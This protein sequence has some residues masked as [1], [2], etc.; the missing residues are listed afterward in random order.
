MSKD[1][2]ILRGRL[3]TKSANKWAMPLLLATLFGPVLIALSMV[4]SETAAVATVFAWIAVITVGWI[5]LL[6][7]TTNVSVGDDGV[8]IER[9]GQRRFVPYSDIAEVA[10]L[11]DVVLRLILHSGES[12]DVYTGKNELLGQKEHYLERVDLIVTRIRSQVSQ[13][14]RRRRSDGRTT[15]AGLLRDRAFVLLRS[16]DHAHGSDAP[17]RSVPAP[18]AS[19]LWRTLESEGSSAMERAVAAVL[20]RSDAAEEVKPRLRIAA[21]GA[22]EP[23]LQQLVRVVAED[24]DDEALLDALTA[25]E[26]ETAAVRQN[27]EG[28]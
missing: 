20:L 17:Y 18:D 24:A 15:A 25:L 21:E 26:E 28:A 19:E 3:F 6:W 27:G 22:V 5:P 13:A 8:L 1:D 7:G 23:G 10:L 9:R 12:V 11:D 14:E 4:I 2:R 16:G